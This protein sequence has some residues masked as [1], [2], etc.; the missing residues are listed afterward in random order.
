MDW[1]PDGRIVYAS[2]VGGESRIW[3]MNADGADQKPLS[4]A[5]KN[6]V[7]PK[8][9]PDGRHIF[10]LTRNTA[11]IWRIESDGTRPTR[12]TESGVEDFAVTPDG[13]WIIYDLYAPGIWKIPAE[14]GTATKLSDTPTWVIRISPDGRLLALNTFVGQT[15]QPRPIVLKFD[16][17]ST[18]KTFDLPI[19]A[20]SPPVFSADSSA[21]IYLD[22]R[23]G[24]TSLWRQPL[25]GSAARQITN[26]SSDRI[27]FFAY[28]RDGK[29]LAFT[30]GN[31]TQDAVIISDEQK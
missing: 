22:T 25:D 11:Q 29:K 16:D 13:R 10:F 5:G 9:S 28:S 31:S 24:V 2:N 1:M 20:S 3:V 7:S 4:E 6:A 26:S 8:V 17:L 14:G 19:T 21:L 15:T 30:R 18:V 27:S 23:D 12:L